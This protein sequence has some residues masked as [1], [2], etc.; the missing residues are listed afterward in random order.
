[1]VYGQGYKFVG[2]V[3]SSASFL[4]EESFSV[5]I[6]TSPDFILFYSRMAMAAG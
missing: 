4:C 3:S 2:E 6:N 1:M 5:L